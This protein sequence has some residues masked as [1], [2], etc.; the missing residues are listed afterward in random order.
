MILLEHLE[1]YNFMNHVTEI[2]TMVT[3]YSA[4]YKFYIAWFYFSYLD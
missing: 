4:M 2:I 3:K 1:Q